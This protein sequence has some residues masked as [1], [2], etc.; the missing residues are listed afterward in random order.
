MGGGA[1]VG[2]GGGAVGGGA[3]PTTAQKLTNPGEAPV[4][5]RH[6]S[7]EPSTT[8]LDDAPPREYVQ[9]VAPGAARK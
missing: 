8:V 9:P 5:Y 1:A 3:Q 4:P 6:P 2:G 7:T